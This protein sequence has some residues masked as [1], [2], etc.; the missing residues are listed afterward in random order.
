MKAARKVFS[1][2]SI[3][4]VRVA[5]ITKEAGVSHG[6]FYVY[7]KNRDDILYKIIS[8][9]LDGI[10]DIATFSWDRGDEADIYS[11]VEH[12]IRTFLDFYSRNADV[13][14]ILVQGSS[15]NDLLDHLYS[16][17]RK[18]IQQRIS[19]NLRAAS[20]KGLTYNIDPEIATFSLAGMVDHF[21][22]TWFCITPFEKRDKF[23][24]DE[25]CRI[26]AEL[27]CNAIYIPQ[28]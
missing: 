7:F 11:N 12:V 8:P 13:M 15:Y 3:T 24:I 9:V 23:E 25:V 19:K 16:D 22:Y 18:R 27:W 26:L 2:S 28:K 5:D 1:E 6:T 14:K 17:A 4:S 20:E 10:Y 21:A